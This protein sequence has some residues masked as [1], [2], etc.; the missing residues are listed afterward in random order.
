MTNP[1]NR[2]FLVFLFSIFLSSICIA[3]QNRNSITGMVYDS[4]NNRPVSDIYVE[5]ANDVYST[6]GRKKTDASGRFSFTGLASGNYKI[7]VLAFGTNF[8]EESKDVDISGIKIGN[9]TTL[10]NAMVDFYLRYDKRKVGF[11]DQGS[12]SSVFLQE[13]PISAQEFYKKAITQLKTPLETDLGMDSLKKA[14]LL[15]PDYYDATLRLGVEYVNRNNFY[16]AIPYLIKAITI[17]KRSFLGFLSIGVSAYNLKQFNESEKAFQAATVINPNSDYA[18]TQ[19]GMILRILGKFK[20]SEIALLKAKALTKS[21]PKSEVHWQLALLY[22]KT[23]RN[24]EAADELEV[25]LIIEPSPK[26]L[27]RIKDLILSLRKK[28]K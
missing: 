7:K 21:K 17:N 25:F 5:L 26:D 23:G 6:L 16:D 24:K 28:V 10:D 3:Q 14:I 18:I 20:D 13:V 2:L 22:E 9:S 1:K 11:S 19:Y 8:Q 4:T 12:P 27:L 15:Y